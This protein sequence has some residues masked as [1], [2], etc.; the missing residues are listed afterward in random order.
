MVVV[1]EQELV[2]YDLTSREE[3]VP[4]YMQALHCSAITELKGGILPKAERDRGSRGEGMKVKIAKRWPILGGSTNKEVEGA[5][6]DSD[7]GL[8]SEIVLTGHANG[9]VK[10]WNADQKHVSLMTELQTAPYFQG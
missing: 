2:A 3:I 10:V 6:I 9:N 7:S 1:T 5:S 4:P 8:S